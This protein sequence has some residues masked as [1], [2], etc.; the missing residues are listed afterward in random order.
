MPLPEREELIATL[1]RLADQGQPLPAAAFHRIDIGAACTNHGVCAGVCPTLALVRYEDADC[2]GVSFD[3]ARCIGCARCVAA[4]PEHALALL[5]AGTMPLLNQA[6]RL[7]THQ[8][9]QCRECLQP[10]FGATEDGRCP[11][12]R[13]NRAMGASL[14]G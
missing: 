14:F 11:G 1:E 5:P 13:R 8:R 12:C 3:A 6:V 4:C 2:A 10:Y 9:H 7:S